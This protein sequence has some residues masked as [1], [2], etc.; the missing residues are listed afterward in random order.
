[1]AAALS[2]DGWKPKLIA[3]DVDGTLMNSKQEL[4]EAVSDAVQK[5]SRAGVPFIIATGKSRGPWTKTVSPYLTTTHSPLAS[6]VNYFSATS[7]SHCLHMCLCIAGSP[8]SWQANTRRLPAGM[9]DL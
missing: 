3:S 6:L 1:M 8:S 7:W 5:A 2:L 4:T 9:P